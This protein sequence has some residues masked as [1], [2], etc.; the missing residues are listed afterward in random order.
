MVD[1]N[2]TFDQI[3]AATN[4][5]LEADP[6]LSGSDPTLPIFQWAALHQL[7][8]LEEAYKKDPFYLMQAIYVCAIHGLPLPDWG[9]CAYLAAYYKI[10][11][12]KSGSWDGVFGR[13][14]PKGAHLAAIRK[15]RKFKHAVFQEVSKIKESQPD[16][17]IDDGLFGK[18]GK[19]FGLGKTL[20]S[21]YY[22]DVERTSF[23]KKRKA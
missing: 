23:S 10:V 2:W 9:S 3:A 4:A 7:D 11:N 15:K 16:V 8:V 20:A 21:E 1:K 6:S 22:Y 17:A 13:P 12:A 18:V 5:A 14:Y 19:K